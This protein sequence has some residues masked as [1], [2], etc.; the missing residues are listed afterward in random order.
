MLANA[1][2]FAAVCRDI[3]HGQKE[4][5]RR[6]HEEAPILT[7]SPSLLH[8]RLVL[9]LYLRPGLTR[10]S[11]VKG[12]RPSV[13]VQHHGSEAFVVDITCAIGGYLIDDHLGGGY[14]S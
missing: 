5:K 11:Q 7:P 2:T 8:F 1:S 13:I 9:I 4:S 10:K 6:L 12:L 3:N 14:P